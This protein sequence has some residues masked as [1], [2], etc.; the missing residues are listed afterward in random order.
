MIIQKV[1][2]LLLMNKILLYI[3][4]ILILKMYNKYLN[5]LNPNK[6]IYKLYVQSIVFQKVL[7]WN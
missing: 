6:I 7:I 1:I 5:N 4:F 2:N 3:K